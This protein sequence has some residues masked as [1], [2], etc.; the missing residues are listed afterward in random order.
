MKPV[1]Q[2]IDGGGFE[3]P[4]E[5]RGDCFRACVASILELEPEALPNPHDAQHWGNTWNLALEAIGIR[6]LWLKDWQGDWFGGYWIACIPSVNIEGNHCVVMHGP[7][8]AHDPGNGRQV[9]SVSLDDI[10]EAV[11]LLPFD[12]SGSVQNREAA[13]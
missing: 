7:K 11:I 10:R 13:A 5:E 8:L 1:K 3:C 2:L 4:P 12:P 6:P 9:E